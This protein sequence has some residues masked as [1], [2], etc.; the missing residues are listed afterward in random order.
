MYCVIGEKILKCDVVEK[1]DTYSWCKIGASTKNL[2]VPNTKLFNSEEE[3]RSYIGKREQNKVDKDK[4]IAN[5]VVK[6]N[7][8]YDNFY[9]ETGINIRVIDRRWK[10][11]EAKIQIDRLIKKQIKRNEKIEANAEAKMNGDTEAGI[12]AKAEARPGASPGGKPSARP[13][14]RPG[15]KPT[16]RSGAKSGSRPGFKPEGRSEGRPGSRPEGRSEGRSWS[17]PEGRSE[18]RS[19][20]K[21]EG[22]SE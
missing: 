13:G 20:S 19:W 7:E 15:G 1:L 12:D 21:P 9:K 17:K 6:C 16:G 8:L 4:Q 18:G 11:K 3:C 5:E 2:S 22:R 14:A 10:A